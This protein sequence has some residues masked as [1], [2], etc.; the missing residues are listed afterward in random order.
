[1]WANY[2]VPSYNYT[3]TYSSSQSVY[4]HCCNRCRESSNNCCAI[5]LLDV[6]TDMMNM[7]TK[8]YLWQWWL[9][10]SEIDIVAAM[11]A[12]ILNIRRGRRKFCS[13]CWGKG[14]ND[15]I[16]GVARGG[17]KGWTASGGKQHG[18][19]KMG[20]MGNQASHDFLGRQKCSPPRAPIIYATPLDCTYWI[21]GAIVATI[22]AIVAVKAAND[23]VC[24]ALNII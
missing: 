24:T 19:R 9:N 2:R 21:Y 12:R 15:C 13:D 17:G 10:L 3:C 18:E 20:V 22:A 8:W 23:D 7:Y 1:M 16:N 6:I 14:C 5:W 11:I 4:S